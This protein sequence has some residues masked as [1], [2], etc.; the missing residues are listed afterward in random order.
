M[1][2]D[3][4]YELINNTALMLRGMTLDPS[5]PRHA[6][7]VMQSRIQVLEEALEKI[8]PHLGS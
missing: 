4:I 8:E 5:I 1:P 6:K 3:E 2:I 7:Q